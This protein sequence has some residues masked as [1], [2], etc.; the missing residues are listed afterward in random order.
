[1]VSREAEFL[2]GLRILAFQGRF[3]VDRLHEDRFSRAEFPGEKHLAKGEIVGDARVV[4]GVRKSR[5]LPLRR[6]ISTGCLPR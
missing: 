1:M 2:Q 6:E 5:T 4:G 3:P